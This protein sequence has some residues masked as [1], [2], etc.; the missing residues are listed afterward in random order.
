MKQILAVDNELCRI[1]AE[2]FPDA[3]GVP[4]VHV[5][6]KSWGKLQYNLFGFVWKQFQLALKKLGY[7][8]VCATILN[9]DPNT[10]KLAETFGMVERF[11]CQQYTLL[12]LEL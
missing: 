6:M 1:W 8:T 4:F 11:K 10:I 3:P 2:E 5:K 7:K 12:A 9:D